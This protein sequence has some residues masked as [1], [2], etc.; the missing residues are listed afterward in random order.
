M[1]E[2]VKQTNDTIKFIKVVS[3]EKQERLG[4]YFRLIIDASNNDGRD[5]NYQAVAYQRDWGEKLS[6]VSFKPANW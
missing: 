4:L 2:H 3:G 6:L 1:T 5:G